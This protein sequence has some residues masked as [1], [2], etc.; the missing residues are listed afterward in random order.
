MHKSVARYRPI[1]RH[2]VRTAHAEVNLHASMAS[3]HVLACAKNHCKSAVGIL[4]G[5]RHASMDR[6]CAT[7]ISSHLHDKLSSQSNE[8]WYGLTLR[9]SHSKLPESRAWNVQ[10]IAEDLA[11]STA[12]WRSW[13]CRAQLTNNWLP[14]TG[15][16]G[17]KILRKWAYRIVISKRRLAS[18]WSSS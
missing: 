5:S 4:T 14:M 7:S 1:A 18:W 3:R 16:P 13:S 17:I 2:L 15:W 6:R 10:M 11:H 8:H 12:S 9:E